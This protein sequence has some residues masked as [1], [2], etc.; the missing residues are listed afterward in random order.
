MNPEKNPQQNLQEP[1]KTAL[2]SKRTLKQDWVLL[3]ELNLRY[4]NQ[5]ARSFTVDPY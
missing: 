5:E 3:T 2:S 4:S 1:F